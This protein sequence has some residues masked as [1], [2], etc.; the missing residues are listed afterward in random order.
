MTITTM[1]TRGNGAAD[2]E[3]L[4]PLRQRIEQIGERHAGDERQQH[5]AEQPE[6]RDQDDERRTQKMSCR[7]SVTL[8][9]PLLHA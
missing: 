6:Q 2:A 8:P 9:R 1:I 4:H 5:V 7:L 3:P